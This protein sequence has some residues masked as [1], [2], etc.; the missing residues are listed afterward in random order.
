MLAERVVACF[1]L[2]VAFPTLLLVA[3]LIRQTGGSPIIVK[4]EKPGGEG[5]NMHRAFR[6]RTNGNGSTYFQAL[7]RFLR[8]YSID[9]LPGLWNVATGHVRLK[10]LFEGS[11]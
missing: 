8:A 9:Q 4:A 7:G 5:V 2:I 11:R 3:L 6:F 1:G 10:V